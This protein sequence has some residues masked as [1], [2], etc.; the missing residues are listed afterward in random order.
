MSQDKPNRL[1]D[2]HFDYQVTKDNKVMLYWHNKHI[3]TL[4][5]KQAHK[6]IGQIAGLDGAEAQLVL[7]RFTG[8]FKRGNERDGKHKRR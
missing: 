7:A 1:D 2:N 4:S 5:G 8:N 3:K 6:F